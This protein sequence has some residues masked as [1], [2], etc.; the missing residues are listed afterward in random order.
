M[1]NQTAILRG[2]NMQKQYKE[3]TLQNMSRDRL[4]ELVLVNQHNY[5]AVQECSDRQ[6]RLLS[7]IVEKYNI[8]NDE[9]SEFQKIRLDEV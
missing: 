2:D 7:K 5:N 4:V 6:Y 3:S 8:S 9:L 1:T